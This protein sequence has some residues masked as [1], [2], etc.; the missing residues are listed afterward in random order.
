[1]QLCTF[2]IRPSTASEKGPYILQVEFL[3]QTNSS[4]QY[5]FCMFG[6]CNRN[7]E[8][9]TIHL[10]ISLNRSVSDSSQLASPDTHLQKRIDF[11][12]V[13][14][15]SV[16]LTVPSWKRNLPSICRYSTEA[17]SVK[18]LSRREGRQPPCGFQTLRAVVQPRW[19]RLPV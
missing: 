5:W 7:A 13:C 14:R 8:W 3:L 10:L 16:A 12:N 9:K 2:A 1:M 11:P 17:P 18:T 4:A 6:G 19:T 15:V